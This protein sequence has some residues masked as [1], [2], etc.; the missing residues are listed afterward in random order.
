MA[1][2]SSGQRS[3]RRLRKALLRKAFGT[4]TRVNGRQRSATGNGSLLSRSGAGMVISA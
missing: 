1:L 4:G 3:V 2:R